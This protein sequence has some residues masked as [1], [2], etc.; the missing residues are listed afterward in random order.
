M[1]S[2]IKLV[3]DLANTEVEVYWD[4]WAGEYGCGSCHSSASS[5]KEIVHL[6]SCASERAKSIV[7]EGNSIEEQII[8]EVKELL[9][10]THE[11]MNTGY[12]E[13]T[14]L[15]IK[16][17]QEKDHYDWCPFKKLEDLIKEYEKE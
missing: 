3:K 11:W 12:E 16:C 17:R 10:R 1:G 6:I 14:K 13:E 5:A 7:K 15:C 4:E 9:T 8:K 2:T